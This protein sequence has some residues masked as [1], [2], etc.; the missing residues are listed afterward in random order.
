MPIVETSRSRDGERETERGR[1]PAR[2]ELE[3]RI[4]TQNENAMGGERDGHDGAQSEQHEEPVQHLEWEG[5]LG[6]SSDA[7]P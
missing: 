5:S 2:N 3:G 6:A 1:E 4:S 7:V